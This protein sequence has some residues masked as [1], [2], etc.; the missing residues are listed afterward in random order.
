M[1]AYVIRRLL[2][3]IPTLFILSILVFLS[4]RFLPGDVIDAM[5]GDLNTFSGDVDRAAL[6]RMLGLDV[7]VPV[8]Y[9]RWIGGIFLHGTLGEFAVER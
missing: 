7:P 5:V 9:G 4:V 3:I 1:R 8:Q 6:E 2:L